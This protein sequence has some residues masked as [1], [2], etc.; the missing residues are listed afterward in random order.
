MVEADRVVIDGAWF[1]RTLGYLLEQSPR[2]ERASELISD[3]LVTDVADAAA[4]SFVTLL[5]Q[6]ARPVTYPVMPICQST[7]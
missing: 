3:A 4:A 2:C 7:L 1:R 5:F 6:E